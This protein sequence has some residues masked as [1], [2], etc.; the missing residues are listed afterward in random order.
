[1]SEENT[2]KPLISI[3]VP[4]YNHQKFVKEAVESVLNQTYS[5]FELIIID[6]CS[7]DNSINIIKSYDDPRIKFYQNEDNMGGYRTLNKAARLAKGD[8]V[9]ILHTDD[10]YD[11]HF[12][13][14][15]VKAYNKYPDSK[16]F[17]TAVYNQDDVLRHI[18]PIYPF[19]SEGIIT[20]K[21]AMTRLTYDNNIGNGVNLVIHKDALCEKDLYNQKYTIVGDLDLFMRLAE[22]YDFVYINKL[23]TYYR[24]HDSNLTH[25]VFLEMVKQSHE[26]YSKRLRNSKVISNDLHRKL[27]RF[28]YKNMINR[29]FYI[30]FKYNSRVLTQDI[31]NFLRELYPEL[32]YSY[33]WYLM[34]LSSFFINNLSS[35]LLIKLLFKLGKYYKAYIAQNVYKLSP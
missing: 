33:Y 23:L 22:N 29:A 27:F 24:M 32:R 15:I 16:V 1:M 21:E 13:E 2:M 12:L 25:K 20:R 31:L 8:L 34:F 35:K 26:V 3:C 6:D 4:S 10:K 18:T 14:E 11:H 28:Q 19:N 9:A 17:V 30:G 5:N 7:V